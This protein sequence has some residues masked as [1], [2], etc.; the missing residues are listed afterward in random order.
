MY[1]IID[2]MTGVH[3]YD[4]WLK[5][6]KEHSFKKEEFTQFGK[7]YVLNTTGESFEVSRDI[8]VLERAAIDKA[9]GKRGLN[10]MDIITIISFILILLTYFALGDLP[11]ITDIMTI[12]Q[13]GVQ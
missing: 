8:K 4:N 5:L 3:V 7:D 13:G 10:G 2:E 9:F 6:K 11:K 12:M 1:I